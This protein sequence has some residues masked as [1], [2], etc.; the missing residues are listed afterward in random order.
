MRRIDLV[1]ADAA[2]IKNK[3]SCDDSRLLAALVCEL[4]DVIADL[5]ERIDHLPKRDSDG[6]KSHP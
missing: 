6:R 4:C 1:N 2:R 5:R 3:A